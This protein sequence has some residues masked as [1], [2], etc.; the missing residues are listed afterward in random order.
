MTTV[1]I[2]AGGEVAIPLAMRQAAGIK[3]QSLVAVEQVGG[4]IVVRPISAAV[5]AY[6]PERK[7]EFLLSN[8]IDKADYAAAATI[9]RQMGLDPQQIPHQRPA[10]V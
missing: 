3:E 7:A 5:E 8:A 4:V 1:Q 9:V 2:G 10:G 6:T